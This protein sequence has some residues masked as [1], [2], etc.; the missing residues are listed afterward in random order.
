MFVDKYNY[1]PLSLATPEGSREKK[2]KRKTRWEKRK[3]MKKSIHSS[4][5]QENLMSELPF[6]LTSPTTWKELGCACVP[7]VTPT[8]HQ[9]LNVSN[10]IC[11]EIFSGSSLQLPE[12]LL[13]SLVQFA[14]TF[15]SLQFRRQNQAKRRE[16]ESETVA[17]GWTARR[18][19]RP[20][21]K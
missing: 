16:S 3:G 13:Q 9:C 4:D 17:S 10:N 15:S 8:P 18:T 7:A 11:I 1:F 12:Y 2:A 20:R 14:L 6:C 19:Q 5:P 21:R